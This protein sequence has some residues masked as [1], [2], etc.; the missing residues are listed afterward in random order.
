MNFRLLNFNRID[1]LEKNELE[2]TMMNV[3]DYFQ[4]YLT[5]IETVVRDNENQFFIMD[6][7]DNERSEV[8]T[9]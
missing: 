6:R 3:P 4:W 2:G 9:W 8:I 1:K 5:G 7:H